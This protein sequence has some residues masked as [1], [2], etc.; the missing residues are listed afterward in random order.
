MDGSLS[1]IWPQGRKII[2]LVDGMGRFLRQS[3]GESEARGFTSIL[4]TEDHD[5]VFNQLSSVFDQL[6][7]RAVA[8]ARSIKLEAKVS[9]LRSS[10]S[11]PS[12][13]DFQHCL[14]IIACK[15]ACRFNLYFACRPIVINCSIELTN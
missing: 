7:I 10:F 6:G 13:K 2:R 14:R 8:L 11:T 4:A 12:A 5:F 9:L 15:D 3:L 1:V